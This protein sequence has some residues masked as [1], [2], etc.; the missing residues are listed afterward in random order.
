MADAGGDVDTMEEE[1]GHAEDVREML[2]LD[3]GEALLVG[4]LVL[5]GQGLIASLQHGLVGLP[6]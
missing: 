2:F 6:P 4:A 5:V 1:V 3:A